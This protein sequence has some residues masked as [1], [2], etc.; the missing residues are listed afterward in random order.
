[1]AQA[2]LLQL[3]EHRNEWRPRALRIAES[4]AHPKELPHPQEQEQLR[5]ELLQ[6][7]CNTRCPHRRTEPGKRAKAQQLVSIGFHRMPRRVWRPQHL[8]RTHGDPR[9]GDYAHPLPQPRKRPRHPDLLV[10]HLR[11]E[12]PADHGD[13][14]APLPQPLPCGQ[15]PFGVRCYTA[16]ATDVLRNALHRSPL[17][18]LDSRGER[19]WLGSALHS[20]LRSAAARPAGFEPATPRSEVWCSVR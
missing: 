3:A 2:V 6:R 7:R 14:P 20:W 9:G 10:A 1:M 19:K 11:H 8:A 16:P 15:A 13:A 12:V 4:I 5:T 18:L 17:L